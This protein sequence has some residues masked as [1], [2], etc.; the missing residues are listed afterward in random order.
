MSA[1][2]EFAD[3]AG[4]NLYDVHVVRKDFPILHQ[5]VNGHPLVY[6]DNGATSQKPQS[7]I[8]AVRQLS[9]MMPFRP[10]L[11]A[12]PNALMPGTNAPPWA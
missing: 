9:P 5:E 8:D 3:Q 2:S 1:A 4:R 12:S 7:V 10:L 11:A 6:L